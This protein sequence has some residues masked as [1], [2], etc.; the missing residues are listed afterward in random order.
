M[1]AEPDRSAPEMPEAPSALDAPLDPARLVCLPDYDEAACTA[2]LAALAN[3]RGG[4]LVVGA[5]RDAGT[6][7]LRPCASRLPRDLH[8]LLA[9]LA[10]RIDPPLTDAVEILAL[11]LDGA[12]LIVVN[13]QR[14][15]HTPHID[16]RS[17]RVFVVGAAGAIEPVRRR[18]DLDRLY[19]R[20]AATEERARRTLDGM[21]EQLQLAS[22]GQYGIAMIAA[23]LQPSA[24]P[25]T[26]WR[27][28]PEAL[29]PAS[30]AF[31]QE[32]GL[33]A[34]TPVV[35]PSWIEL[36]LERELTGV[37][38]VTR[39]GCAAA[40]ETRS[41]PSDKVIESIEELQE[42]LRRLVDST[43]RLLAPAEDGRILPRLL[44]EGMRGSRLR[45]GEGAEPLSSPAGEDSIERDCPA[46]EVCDAGY[47][48][49]LA[50]SFAAHLAAIYKVNRE[51]TG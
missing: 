36:R 51:G 3:S 41:L 47:R 26:A 32:W 9:A 2:A 11:P 43:C 33:S 42:R 25:L 30:D 44:C 5:V 24:A 6:G 23:L 45:T 14:S 19:G 37:L 21:V 18:A 38:R 39:A 4:D 27:E 16:P 8:V 22:F 1:P 17:G 28:R 12:D 13:V 40:A 31:V 46:G 35:R 34:A 29:A 10:D 20:G 7:R 15:T 50:D 48:R 49:Y